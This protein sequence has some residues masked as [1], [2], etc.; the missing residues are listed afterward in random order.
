MIFI[1]SNVSMYLVGAPHPHKAGARA[2]LERFVSEGERLVTDAEV[3]QELLHRY[4]AI[5]RL[6]AIEPAFEA[7][8]GSGGRCVSSGSA[9]RRTREVDSARDRRSLGA[10]CP[11]SRRDGKTGSQ[12]DCELR[13]RIRRVPRGGKGYAVTLASGPRLGRYELVA[14]VGGGGATAEFARNPMT[15]VLN[16]TAGLEK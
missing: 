14:P 3:F 5:Q 8:L 6:D 1:D 15:L 4:A 7:L 13:R 11:S 12:S 10:G 9:S 16:S 2:L